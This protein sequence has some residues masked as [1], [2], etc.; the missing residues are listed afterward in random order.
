MRRG[1]RVADIADSRIDV[2]RPDACTVWT[3][4]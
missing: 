2:D 1:I 3:L 4:C